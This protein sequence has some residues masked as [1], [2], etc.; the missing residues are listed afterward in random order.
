MGASGPSCATL[1]QRDWPSERDQHPAPRMIG[2]DRGAVCR[3]DHGRARD[4]SA[5]TRTRVAPFLVEPA[6]GSETST[7]PRIGTRD[8][9][10]DPNG[11]RCLTPIDVAAAM[12]SCTV[13]PAAMV[14]RWRPWWQA[15]L[16]VSSRSPPGL[17]RCA[18][19]A[20]DLLPN[21]LASSRPES[22]HARDRRV[23]VQAS[24]CT[25]PPQS[26][27]FTHRCAS[28]AWLEPTAAAGDGAHALI[29]AGA[30]GVAHGLRPAN[31]NRG[32]TRGSAAPMSAPRSTSAIGPRVLHLAL[33]LAGRRPPRSL[34]PGDDGQGI[35]ADTE[36]ALAS[37]TA[38]K[39]FATDAR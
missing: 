38:A 26:S 16:V 18:D 11:C 32:S 23:R 30:R 8:A 37:V 10:P 2:R 34:H 14:G 28:P 1:P 7:R 6:V 21:R 22:R 31:I 17:R 3:G 20:Q 27:A 29:A 9:R 24:R 5:S 39:E 15:G 33:A 25:K 36:R 35:P 12:A 19:G 4:R 13:E